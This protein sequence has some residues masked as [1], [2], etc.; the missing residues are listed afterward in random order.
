MFVDNLIHP[1]HSGNHGGETRCGKRQKYSVAEFI[2][3]YAF[4]SLL[5]SLC[6]PDYRSSA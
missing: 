2:G 6:A 3:G 4:F 1:L 5:C